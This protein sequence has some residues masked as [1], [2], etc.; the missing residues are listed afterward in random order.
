MATFMIPGDV[1]TKTA[2]FGSPPP[3]TGYYT[4]TIDE[5]KPHK[6]KASSRQ[7]FV[8]F[9]TGFSCFGWMNVPF[10]SNGNQLPGLSDKQVRGMVGATK[11]W[12]ISA[13]FT[14][15]QMKDGVSD[16][17]LVG[18][19]IH[20]EWH[21]ADD[22]G[23]QYGELQM[24]L[25]KSVFDKHIAEGRKP[26]IAGAGNDTPVNNPGKVAAKAN[27]A[28]KPSNGGGVKLPPPPAVAATS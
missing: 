27:G 9:E 2:A 26:S 3:A 16:D 6:S 15:E 17:W 24:P 1:I 20:V 7:V 18:K 10:D 11:S 5:I 23:A 8:T 4:A 21:S 22:L 14:N 13:G 12:F 28:G 25:P 19:T